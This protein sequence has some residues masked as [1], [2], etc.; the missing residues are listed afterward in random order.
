MDG[1]LVVL[2]QAVNEGRSKK[3]DQ[4]HIIGY[5]CVQFTWSRLVCIGLY[6]FE[7]EKRAEVG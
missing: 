6:S 5:G 7:Q 1:R 4:L 2:L 3:P